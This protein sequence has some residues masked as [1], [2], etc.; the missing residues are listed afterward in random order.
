MAI[1]SSFVLDPLNPA[2]DEQDNNDDKQDANN[3][4]AC[5]PKAEAIGDRAEPPNPSD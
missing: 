2:H 4:E 5:T 1:R 3:A